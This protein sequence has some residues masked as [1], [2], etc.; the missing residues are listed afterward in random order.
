MDGAQLDS[1][2]LGALMQMQSEGPP[3]LGGGNF[4]KG[5]YLNALLSW[6]CAFI[7]DASAEMAGTAG[8]YLSILVSLHGPPHG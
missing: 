3:R 8:D 7:S 2:H 4:P 1:S 6:M 5:N